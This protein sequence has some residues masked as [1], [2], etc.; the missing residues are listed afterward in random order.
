MRG[1]GGPG[2]TGVVF[3]AREMTVYAQ[4]L[5]RSVLAALLALGVAGSASAQAGQPSR[6]PIEGY[7]LRPFRLPPEPALPAPH[8]ANIAYAGLGLRQ[9]PEGVVVVGVQPGPFGGDGA[10]SPSIWRGDLIVS[11]NGQSLDASGYVRLIRALAPG[12]TLHVVYRRSAHADPL[13][14]VPRG[15]P[16]GEERSV[17]VVLDDAARWRGP[18]GQGL[19]PGRAIAAASAGEFE[20][21]V[22]EKADALGLRA[23]PGGLDAQMAFLASLQ[24]RLLDPNSLPA[25]V[26]AL[27]RPLSI[28]RVESEIA[29]RARPLAQPQPLQET[30]AALHR[31]VVTTLD[32][33]EVPAK[34]DLAL[35]LAAARGD[36]E[37]AAAGLLAGMRDGNP[38]AS[39]DFARQLELMRASP[40]LVPLPVAM[41]P[42][43]AR[44]ADELEQFADEAAA[45]PQDVPSDLAERVRAAVEGTVLGAKVVDGGLWVVG[46]D[47]DN[48][49][50]MQQVAAVFDPGGADAYIFASPAQG[51]YQIIID[52][53]GDDRYEAFADLGGPAAAVFGVSI[54]DD[55]AGNDRYF[56]RHQGAI[57]AGVFGVAVLIDSAGH[58]RYVND[59]PG[60]GWSQGI[61][62][63]GAGVL[64]DRAGDDRYEGQVLAQGVGGP[65]GLGLVVDV[66]GDDVYTANGPHFPSAY[67]TAGVF[68]GLSQGFGVGLRGYAAGGVGA[69]YDFSGDDA[70]AVGEFGQGTGYFQGLGI[71]HDA[72]GDDGYAGSRYAQGSAAHHAAGI[73][74]DEAG[75]DAYA[76]SGPAAQAG[77]W[78]MSVAMLID[79]AGE[80]NY[81]AVGLAQGSAAQQAIAIRLDLSGADAYSCTGSCLGRSGDNVYHYDETGVFSFS[82]AIDLGGARDGYPETLPN[83]AL[84]V[85]GP[86][87][88]ERSAD[89]G[90]CGLFLDE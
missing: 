64:I 12:D 61:G 17:A 33:E 49:Y 41:L 39:A 67:G 84:R 16:E 7:G 8:P 75:N 47:G 90:C 74:V 21:F 59:G 89:S 30:L 79:H 26:Q 46:G 24:R 32:V 23:A 65:A 81:T 22:L 31:L 15:D 19:R 44:R 48:R 76:C 43:V 11:M 52:V 72:A 73:L 14:A 80:D 27:E 83:D 5:R 3:A 77:A 55:R 35:A 68:W 25:V 38:T 6:Q 13:A 54:L 66:A 29:A 4:V 57:A 10:T 28:D 50:D 45:S 60:A 2:G 42:S 85:T 87:A 20:A 37:R 34:P 40:Q 9:N 82:A 69:L 62:V 58:D 56:S 36:Y 1:C 63:Y 51:P 70:Y 53:S 78:D 18:L 88:P 71:L 86:A